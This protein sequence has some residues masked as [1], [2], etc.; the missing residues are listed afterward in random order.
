MNFIREFIGD[1]FSIDESKKSVVIIVFLLFSG[2]GGYNAI[3]NGD[4]SNN[5]TTIILTLGGI[6]FGVNSIGNIVKGVNS[7]KQ[8]ESDEGDDFIV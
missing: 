8:I 4:I 5:M 6:I 7:K 1:F 2:I 3:Y